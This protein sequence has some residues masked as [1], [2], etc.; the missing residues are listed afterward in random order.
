LSICDRID[1]IAYVC[2]PLSEVVLVNELPL[3][4][5][6]KIRLKINDQ[7]LWASMQD[8][9][10][11]VLRDSFKLKDD[12]IK[13]D[14]THEI[15]VCVL[16]GTRLYDIQTCQC[17]AMM[18]QIQIGDNIGANVILRKASHHTVLDTHQILTYDCDC[19]IGCI[20]III[21]KQHFKE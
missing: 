12:D 1:P 4:M 6:W 19:L 17:C 8:L 5:G 7:Q 18:H 3:N 21:K 20:D 14:D 15:S 11:Q 16:H 2:I 9:R 13:H 10:Q